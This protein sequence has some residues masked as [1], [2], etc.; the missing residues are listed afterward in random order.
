MK[1]AQSGFRLIEVAIIIAIIGILA[2]VA[3][4]LYQNH[5]AD[6]NDAIVAPA[7]GT[8]GLSVSIRSGRW[9]DRG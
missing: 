5:A 3:A 4:P 2:S 8:T 6:D 1:K 9:P 7:I